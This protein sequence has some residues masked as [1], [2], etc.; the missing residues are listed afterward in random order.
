VKAS[1]K[2]LALV[3]GWIFFFQFIDVYYIITP[4]YRTSGPAPALFDFL[5][6][7]GVG[8]LWLWVFC[9]QI[10]HAELY[11]VHDMRLMEAADHA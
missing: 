4:M 8:G 7:I 5:A 3:A 11:P 6:L 2:S 10:K 9:G 1:P